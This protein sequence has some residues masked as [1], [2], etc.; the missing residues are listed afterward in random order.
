M[1]VPSLSIVL[2]D[3]NSNWKDALA[4]N[5]ITN[6]TKAEKCEFHSEL[7]EYLGYILFPFG[8]IISND[9]VKIIQD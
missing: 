3:N 6:L 4:T 1:P 2:A 5:P 8:L 9:K 7:V